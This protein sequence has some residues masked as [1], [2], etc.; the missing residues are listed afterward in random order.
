MD[1]G[2][3]EA[4]QNALIYNNELLYE[5]SKEAL[6]LDNGNCGACER[7]GFPI[8]LVRKSIVPK[9]F[10]KSID[11]SKG[12]LSLGGD[13][14]PKQDFDSH[15]YAYRTMREGYIYVLLEKKPVK[16]WE[17]TNLS[18]LKVM[19]YEVTNSGAFRLREF[20]DIKGSRP[21]EIPVSCIN[22][23][24]QFKAK[25]ITI[26]N[27]I[28]Q[29]A[30]IAYSPHKWEKEM[31]EFYRDN[32]AERNLR[33][34]IV[35]LS[36]D[37]PIEQTAQYQNRSFPISDFSNKKKY[38]LEMECSSDEV[39]D[40]FDEEQQTKYRKKIKQDQEDNIT[41]VDKEIGKGLF[42]TKNIDLSHI[43]EKSSE[44]I[45][46]LFSDLFC[47]ASHF[48]SLLVNNTLSSEFNRTVNSYKIK[49]KSNTNKNYQT[50]DISVV[51]VEDSLG[52]AE[53][54][55]IQR[56]QL[57]APIVNGL[58][59]SSQEQVQAIQTR[60]S[61]QL[62][63]KLDN[64]K[65]T[66]LLNDSKLM[67]NINSDI[68]DAFYQENILDLRYNQR[69]KDIHE[70]ADS[71]SFTLPIISWLVKKGTQVSANIFG[72]RGEAIKNYFE[73]QISLSANKPLLYFKPETSFS[74]NQY[75]N[76]DSYKE[77]LKIN[78]ENNESSECIFFAF[79]QPVSTIPTRDRAFAINLA[80]SYFKHPIYSGGND[81]R[82]LDGIAI[83]D[84]VG[85]QEYADE[86]GYFVYKHPYQLIRHDS[87]ASNFYFRYVSEYGSCE[88]ANAQ[89]PPLGDYEIIHIDD[90]Q[91][92]KIL[93]IY[94]E[95]LE[96]SVPDIDVVVVRFPDAKSNVAQWKRDKDWDKKEGKHTY[97]S[98]LTRYQELNK[99]TYNNVLT[100][101]KAASKDY[102]TYLLWLFDEQNKVKFWLRENNPDTSD[103]HIKSLSSLLIILDSSHLGNLYLEE[104][105]QL[106]ATLL[107]SKSSFYFH[108]LEGNEYSLF[109]IA[110]G[111]LAEEDSELTAEVKAI[112]AKQI[113]NAPTP[114]TSIK[115]SNP[116]SGAKSAIKK[117]K[118]ITNLK[119]QGNVKIGAYLKEELIKL[120]LSNFAKS[121]SH[122]NTYNINRNVVNEHLLKAMNMFTTGTFK[123]YKI[124]IPVHSIPDF[125]NNLGDYAPMVLP[126]NGKL[127]TS[128]GSQVRAH[129]SMNKNS[130]TLRPGDLKSAN[131]KSVQFTML[132][133]FPDKEALK[134]FDDTVYSAKGHGKPEKFIGSTLVEFEELQAAKYQA[135]K[136]WRSAVYDTSISGAMNVFS[137]VYENIQVSLL[138]DRLKMLND[139]VLIEK[140]SKQITKTYINIALTISES[141]LLGLKFGALFGE[142]DKTLYDALG[143]VGKYLGYVG[144]TLSLVDSFSDLCLAS[145][146][147]RRGDT[148]ASGF[149]INSTIAFAAA[150][151]GFILSLPLTWVIVLA[152]V[153]SMINYI[154]GTYDDGSGWDEMDKW[155]N[156]CIFGRF[157]RGDL[158][159][160]FPIS[161][162]GN[163]LSNQ[164]YYLASRKGFCK[165]THYALT[166]LGDIAD[167]V[168]KYGQFSKPSVEDFMGAYYNLHL[169]MQLPDFDRESSNFEGVITIRHKDNKQE[170]L[171][172]IRNGRNNL[173]IELTECNADYFLVVNDKMINKGKVQYGFYEREDGAEEAKTKLDRL[174]KIKKD[175]LDMQTV[176]TIQSVAG[177]VTSSTPTIEK[178]IGSPNQ[179]SNSTEDNV[180][181]FII[182]QMLGRV[183]GEFEVICQI[184]YWPTG[185]VDENNEPQFPLLLSYQYNV[186]T[187]G[188]WV[189]DKVNGAKKIF[190]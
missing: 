21:K 101:V 76:I 30:W 111:N 19:A 119:I 118:Y 105:S 91:K 127:I 116:L 106:W 81:K 60:L 177:N 178:T 32:E 58:T 154:F 12:M 86:N 63:Q 176:L 29:K 95:R 31:V 87:V 183:A 155:V 69:Y 146:G 59:G 28:Y 160:P 140:L 184:K 99:I 49:N 17:G 11:W 158:F 83:A 74:R 150:G 85:A 113:A 139:Q 163:Y 57:L 14:E 171:L 180:G 24:H 115:V 144:K 23:G 18:L 89:T 78:K 166:I 131:G 109:N 1:E 72:A 79:Y 7:S 37:E 117:S 186:L 50:N 93:K 15:K 65:E 77:I 188:E 157:D 8:F 16:E 64:A 122:N 123:E 137:L 82:F 108:L 161:D 169:N 20:R 164:D 181:L 45:L 9:Y 54:L 13:R 3:I 179:S 5:A 104:Q 47:T 34:T 156:R 68:A 126:K 124:S 172:M 168:K 142:R 152:L 143:K 125:L 135:E 42:Y 73:E 27:K 121:L 40:Y 84:V 61:S 167:E 102:F 39:L 80:Q 165:T 94:Q 187:T 88:R 55:S 75:N 97:N 128:S 182:N 149:M 174:S 185:K 52:L 35:D 56:R 96:W 138:K 51:L 98:S 67:K 62:D 151:I 162:T 33:F 26:D 120:S 133:T 71:L 41:D 6:L 141:I 190:S 70:F 112:L 129:Y 153:P 132:M 170:S 38:L 147:L 22:E 92:Q 66:I 173:I 44:E 136:K 36:K 148:G 2:N 107:S 110:S 4:N 48:N 145:T 10:K 159:P 189:D 175:W 134:Q 46:N 25:F 43:A 114:K 100:Y 90:A 53:E 103:T 130:Y